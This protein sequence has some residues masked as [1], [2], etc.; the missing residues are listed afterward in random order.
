MTSEAP[1]VFETRSLG[2]TFGKGRTAVRALSGVDLRVFAGEF[3]VVAGPSGSGKSTLLNLLAGLDRPDEGTILVAGQNLTTLGEA[4]CASVRR[5]QLGFVFQAFN[6]IPVLSA[7]ENVEY[8]L[9]LNGVSREERRR[10]VS[11]VLKTVGLGDRMSHRP[12]HLSGGERQRVALARALVHEPMAVL[13]DEPTASLDSHTA[14][15][16]LNLFIQ[17]NVSRKT[18]FVFATHDPAIIGRAPRVVR[19]GDGHIVADQTADPA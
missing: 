17:L 3:V 10:R 9:W 12:D 5:H 14:A 6:L 13:A 16:I 19:L 18:T 2:K 15:D 11:D 8:G 1:V 7:Y 4:A